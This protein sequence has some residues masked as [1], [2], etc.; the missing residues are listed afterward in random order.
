MIIM[1]NSIKR[2]Y[3]EFVTHSFLEMYNHN[4]CAKSDAHARNQVMQC[5]L[6]S[7]NHAICPWQQRFAI[8][9]SKI[10][11]GEDIELDTK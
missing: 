11:F 10:Y 3:N 6:K 5:F 7:R 8:V 1:G 9:T 2:E 4:P